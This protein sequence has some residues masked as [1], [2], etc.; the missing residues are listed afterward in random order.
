MKSFTPT[1]CDISKLHID[2]GFLIDEN[3]I[4]HIK[5]ENSHKGYLQLK[6]HV[7]DL[8]LQ[9]HFCMEAT[10]NYYEDFADFLTDCGYKVSVINPLKIK[11]F[12]KTEFLRTKTD[13]QDAKMIARYCDKIKPQ[14]IYVKPTSIQHKIRRNIAGLRQLNKDLNAIKNRIKAVK[15]AHLLEIFN[16]H[17]KMIESSI[18]QLK[19]HIADLTQQSPAADTATN[20]QTMPS[21]GAI[22]AATLSHF[23]TLYRFQT[24]NQFVAFAG[25][26]PQKEQSGTSVNKPDKLSKYGNRTLKG[27]LYMSALVCLRCGYFSAF[28]ERLR[29]R[30]KPSKVIIVALMRK[31]AGIAWHLWNKGESFDPARY[32]MQKP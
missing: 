10:G 7:D 29:Q 20:L 11:S 18:K 23:L 17:R 2:I 19:Q 6:Q 27:S 22:T 26:S 24:E 12:A 21:F 25:L 28:V 15:D 3:A 1:G 5:I 9:P 14:S 16:T 30:N 32:G 31:L 8:N 13:K 4:T